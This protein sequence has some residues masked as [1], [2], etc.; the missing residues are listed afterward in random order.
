MEVCKTFYTS[1]NLVLASWYGEYSLMVGRKIVVLCVAVRFCLFTP[2]ESCLSGL[3]GRFAKPL[4][5]VNLYREFESLTLR[6]NDLDIWNT[7]R[8]F[9][10]YGPLVNRLRR[11]PFTE[12]WGVRFPYGLQRLIGMN[13]VKCINRLETPI[14]KVDVHAPIFYFPNKLPKHCRRCAWLVI[15]I[16][17]FDSGWKLN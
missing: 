11:L 17:R 16:I 12:E 5:G 7:F 13:I 10:L 3:K 15:K 1:S 14:I 4:Y 8:I 6:I 2:K 9:V